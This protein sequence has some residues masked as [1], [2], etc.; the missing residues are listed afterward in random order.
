MNPRDCIFC[1]ILAGRADATFVYRDED[2][3][4]FMD[5]QPV[6]PGH[7]L[8]TPTR[9]EANLADLRPG[10]W[11]R[12]TEI[13][14]QIAASLRRSGL[15]CE[16]VN[17]FMADGESAGQE[18][19]HAHLHVI[20]R[21]GGDGFGLTFPEGYRDLPSRSELEATAAGLRDALASLS[22]EALS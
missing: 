21:F 22:G 3:A 16:A 2:C 17:L 20:P 5:I 19:F 8:V 1:E 9:H 14:R 11:T 7:V 12:V 15:R 18:V 4:A 10:E 13:G 6:N